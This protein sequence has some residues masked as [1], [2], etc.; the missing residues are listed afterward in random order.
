MKKQLLE[1]CITHNL[2]KITMESNRGEE[3][4]TFEIV[5]YDED[6]NTFEI[7]YYKEGDIPTNELM[8]GLK[9]D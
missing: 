8:N 1:L 9:S 4:Y 6:E 2:R 3:V 5:D 7:Q